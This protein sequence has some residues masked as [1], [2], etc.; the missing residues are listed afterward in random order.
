MVHLNL[1]KLHP[2]KHS[3]ANG[4]GQYKLE[5]TQTQAQT[6]TQTQTQNGPS[7]PPGA[8]TAPRSN[9]SSTNNSL[10]D[11]NVG[12]TFCDNRFVVKQPL[13]TGRYSNVWLVQDN[14]LNRLVA[15][16]ILG[17]EFYHGVPL[18]ELEV[19]RRIRD[20]SKKSS[21]PGRNHVMEFVD[22]FETTQH[23]CISM[24]CTI[25]CNTKFNFIYS[26]NTTSPT[27]LRQ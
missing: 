16:K 5:Q 7:D 20:V 18:F 19:M 9:S 13:G 3:Q 14:K 6:R 12:D 17:S 8:K 11:V 26:L 1:D 22:D 2:H 23:K 15:L 10:L 27:F 24:G 25:V 21:H 4:H